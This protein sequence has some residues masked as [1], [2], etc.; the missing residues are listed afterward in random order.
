M[1]KD[2]SRVRAVFDTNT[3]LS[4][5]LFPKGQL[6]WIRD[7]WKS[8]RVKALSCKETAEELIRTLTY[9]K[10]ALDEEEIQ[11]FLS[12]YLPYT[13][14]IKLK[15]I[16]SNLPLCRDVKD[17]IFLQLAHLGK[18]D[19]LVTSDTDLLVLD[20]KADFRIIKHREFKKI[21]AF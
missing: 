15:K 10:F 4:A 13:E 8:G 18:A 19:Y 1:G 11:L 3:V 14:V 12:D 5:L 16:T 7:F 21:G 17:Q 9:P 2:A 20:G 6:T